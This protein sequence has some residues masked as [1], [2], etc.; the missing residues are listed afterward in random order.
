MIRKIYHCYPGGK[1]KALTLSYDDGKLEDKKLVSIFNKYGLKGTFHLNYGYMERPERIDK[2]EIKEI[3]KGHEI[4]SHTYSH[5][6]ISRCPIELVAAQVLEDRKGLEEITGVPVRGL[7]YPNGSYN[8]QI[9]Q[10]LPGLGIKYSRIVGN[11]DDFS[12][13]S[14][15]YEW[16]AT[17]HHN[18]NLLENAK[19]FVELTKKQYMYL[20]YVWG[21]SFEFSRD[22]NWELIEE[23][24]KLVSA[25]KDDIW[26]A[27][28]I[29]IVD[30]F[31]AVDRLQF[32]A[33]GSF[34]YN[35][36]V[37]SVWLSVENEIYEVKGGELKRFD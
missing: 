3:Y 1:Y 32:A 19:R 35:P 16:K 22:D 17:C 4:A 23:F 6:T 2:S 36:S 20:M 10:L 29:E 18:H 28:N 30:Y 12:I 34:V 15:Y 24:A 9:K 8:E 11:T 33:D 13:P 21:H 26:F 27:A 5:P 14:D 7:S 37:Q 31:E 25:Y